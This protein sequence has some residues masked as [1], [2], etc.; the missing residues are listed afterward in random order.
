MASGSLRLTVTAAT[1]VI[2]A[3]CPSLDGFTG[4]DASSDAVNPS[5]GALGDAGGDA[6]VSDAVVDAFNGRCNLAKPFGTPLGIPSINDGLTNI[7]AGRMSSDELTLFYT[8]DVTLGDGGVNPDIFMATRAT[9]SDPWSAGV[10]VSTINSPTTDTDAFL[11][12]DNLTL[13]FSSYRVSP[14]QLFV[15]KR[16]NTTSPFGAPTPV[17]SGGITDDVI[18]V[19][20][21]SDGVTAYFTD[22]A[23][24]NLIDQATITPQQGIQNPQQLVTDNSYWPCVTGDGLTM[25]YDY[26]ANGEV[27]ITT[28]ANTQATFAS[29]AAVTE[30][31][32]G[33]STST[34]PTWVSRDGCV[35][36]LASDRGQQGLSQIYVAQRGL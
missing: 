24:N 33:P 1:A 28:R 31:A 19:F 2:L 5:D 8:A 34:S 16:A 6:I 30:L 23:A 13:F 35:V 9:T 27:Y 15:S 29:G 22:S 32:A 14:I 26:Q 7:Y 12:D 3:G 21:M 11:L 4:G 25:L 18:N 36:V 17:S 20:F 10:A